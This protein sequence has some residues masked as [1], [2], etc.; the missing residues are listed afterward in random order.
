MRES[1]GE[2]RSGLGDGAMG[3][4]C[5]YS[6]WVD[7]QLVSLGADRLVRCSSRLEQGD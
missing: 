3:R 2:G 7:R 6:G 4:V 5:N 1:A